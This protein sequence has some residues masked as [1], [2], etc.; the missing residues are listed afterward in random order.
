MW[1]S[2][3]FFKE[4]KKLTKQKEQTE[5]EQKKKNRKLVKKSEIYIFDGRIMG[6]PFWLWNQTSCC[7]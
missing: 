6:P 5:L 7:D 4:V 2:K 1:N 3:L